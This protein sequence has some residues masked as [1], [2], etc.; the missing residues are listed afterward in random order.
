[1]SVSFSPNPLPKATRGIPFS[2]TVNFSYSPGSVNSISV[3]YNEQ[4]DEVELS[5]GSTSFTASGVY[6]S[7]WED[8]FNFVETD[9]SVNNAPIQ[10]AINIDNMPENK[11][12]FDL[13]QDMAATV[14]KIYSV[15]VDYTNSETF[16]SG[17]TIIN[18]PHIVE[19][20]WEAIRYF[21]DNYNYNG[22]GG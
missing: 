8:I 11:N 7:G 3:V 5:V 18:V 4:G 12:L 14:T 20:D 9:K 1:M 10:T 13:T 2:Q 21:M 6:I 22:T 16:S 17:T 15:T 19:N